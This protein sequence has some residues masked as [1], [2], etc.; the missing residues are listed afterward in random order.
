MAR[1]GFHGLAGLQ[2]RRGAVAPVIALCAALVAPWSTRAH[3]DPGGGRVTVL[4][5]D[6][7]G[8]MW[9]QLA[10]G[11]TKVEVAR[12]V[13]GEFLARRDAA[14]PLGVVAYGHNR[15][16]DC[17]DIEE[18]VPVGVH[19]AA[20]VAGQ[21]NRI[22]PVGMTPLTEALQRAADLIPASAESADI[23]L[24][25][26]GLE[27][28]D[29]DPCALAARLTRQGIRLRAHVVGFGLSDAQ[30][31][32][33]ACVSTT[34]GGLLLT[35]RSGD[36]LAQ[37]LD[38]IADLEP[39]VEIDTEAPTA[40]AYFDIGPH[41]EAGHTY[42]IGYRG[43]VPPDYFAGFTARDAGKPDVSAS[44]RVVGGAG[45][46]GNNPVSRAAPGEPGDYDLIMVAHDGT[47]IAR[48]AITVV[49]ARNGFDAVGTV[50]PAERFVIRWRGPDQLGER[51][52]IARPD[53]PIGQLE[54]DWGNALHRGGEMRLA[55]PAQPGIYELRYLSARLDEV[56]FARRFGVGVAF[57]D[58]D[59]SGTAELARQAAAAVQATP[60]QDDLPPVRARF[61][62]PD[63][64][65][66]SP[67]WWSA[68]PLDAAVSPEAWA[69]SEAT[70]V[71]EGEFEPGR[72]EVRALAPG[73]VV[74]SRI[75][76]ILPGETNEFVIP[77]AG[78][79][80]AETDA[81][82]LVQV[83]VVACSDQPRGCP[84]TDA[85]TGLR[86]VVP[87]GWSLTQPFFHETAAGT[88]ASIASATLFRSGAEG[89]QVIE[90][91]PRHWPAV[92]G[93]CLD[94]GAH[95]ICHGEASDATLDQALAVLL[96]SLGSGEP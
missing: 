77:L 86:L 3:A 81:D 19:E 60:G 91:N 84:H 89:I 29:A 32:A 68:I 27:T 35:P 49:P 59:R 75:V 42:R 26:D 87:D 66:E 51:V 18:L 33:L 65:P 80:D 92:R 8:S 20:D 28:C 44:F 53:D 21:L 64:F 95:R 58:S 47:I 63:G 85:Q 73:E 15:R 2:R 12:R 48:Q 94:R 52:V 72:Y 67:L 61:R 34:T 55:A 69:P 6:A 79:Q 5:Y 62:I 13:L 96:D 31:A 90:L 50:A 4:V 78:E 24:V 1:P 56:L 17:R 43:R 46:S 41:G 40:P 10:D 11:T 16:G 76:E 25:T 36:E 14:V 83:A 30:A 70:V 45:Q 88:T 71:G 38:V 54:Y 23:V 57:Q 93:D 39:A 37:A 9:G 22:R 7:S 82:G 74:F